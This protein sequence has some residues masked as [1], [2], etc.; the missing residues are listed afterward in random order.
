MMMQKSIIGIAA[1]AL[2]GFAQ[3]ARAGSDELHEYAFYAHLSYANMVPMTDSQSVG[4]L[5]M[6]YNTHGIF[7]HVNFFLRG[8]TLDDLGS[9]GP[10]GTAGHL[11]LAPKDEEGPIQVDFDFHGDW[12]AVE[13]G[14]LFEMEYMP[15]GGL[16]GN[17]ESEIF[18]AVDALW[19]A[20]L[21]AIVHTNAYPDGEIRGQ[22]S[23]CK[24]DFNRDNRI[25][26][27]DFIEFLNA[28][29]LQD[30]SADFNVDG[31]TNIVDF[32]DFL[33]AF[34]EGCPF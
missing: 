29:S 17:F 7:V 32:I 19:D 24:G 26:T 8:I 16:Q 20:Q 9:A 27:L 2:V 22:I 34:N 11:H 28:Y 5:E 6:I 3:H 23:Y 13:G 4:W 15:F 21:Y 14:V 33:N 25:N 12:V 31:T 1:W 18:E 30:S 10:N